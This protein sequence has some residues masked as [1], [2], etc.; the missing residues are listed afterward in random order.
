MPYRIFPFRLTKNVNGIR[1]VRFRESFL[2]EF[3][4]MAFFDLFDHIVFAFDDERVDIAAVFAVVDITG[5]AAVFNIQIGFT[6]FRTNVFHFFS[7]RFQNAE[8]FLINECFKEHNSKFK[9]FQP[10]QRTNTE[11]VSPGAG[12]PD[13]LR[14]IF[15]AMPE[16]RFIGIMSGRA[17][18]LQIIIMFP[19]I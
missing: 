18:L 8:I 3:V 5:D 13:D 4:R 7:L 12:F 19:T 6:A 11:N 14:L 1:S 9:A 17:D 15:P 10:V 16:K 2:L